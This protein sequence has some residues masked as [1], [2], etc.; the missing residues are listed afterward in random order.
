MEQVLTFDEVFKQDADYFVMPEELK[1]TRTKT[2]VFSVEKLFGDKGIRELSLRS[3]K[4]LYNFLTG[5]RAEEY[6]K[7]IPDMENPSEWKPVKKS[8]IPMTPILAVEEKTVHKPNIT[9]KP[10]IIPKALE[11][12]QIAQNLTKNMTSLEVVQFIKSKG[13][14]WT[15]NENIGINTMRAKM[16]LTKAIKQ[17]LIID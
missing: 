15:E 2:G 10:I 17:G 13:V 4:R 11:P 1:I 8:V 9:R 12:K 3:A 6:Q 5:W 16:A 7:E 14:T